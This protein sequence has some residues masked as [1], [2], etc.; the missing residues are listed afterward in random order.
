MVQAFLN[1][2]MGAPAAVKEEASAPQA[3]MFSEAISA[4]LGGRAPN[5]PT[6]EVK[7]RYQAE[8]VFVY[9]PVWLISN[10]F[11]FSVALQLLQGTNPFYFFSCPLSPLPFVLLLSFLCISL[12]FGYKMFLVKLSLLSSSFISLLKAVDTQTLQ[13]YGSFPSWIFC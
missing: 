9:R 12:S 13:I 11:L 3:A 8:V 4:H 6:V 10:F 7:V 5:T 1:Q 2:T